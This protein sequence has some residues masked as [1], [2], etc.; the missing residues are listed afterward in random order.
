M[1]GTII[2]T[3]VHIKA[4][5]S[6]RETYV[7]SIQ[8]I[9]VI[10]VGFFDAVRFIIH[11]R[12]TVVSPGTEARNESLLSRGENPMAKCFASYFLCGTLLWNEVT[13]T[14]QPPGRRKCVPSYEHATALNE[15]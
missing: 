15:K 13:S 8:D 5:Y 1:R 9:D 2:H 6:Y 10:F 4:E 3:H 14:I 11:K 12:S 7:K